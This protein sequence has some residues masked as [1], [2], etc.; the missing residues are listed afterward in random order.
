MTN[1]T[2]GNLSRYCD[3]YAAELL[4]KYFSSDDYTGGWFE[5]FAGGGD[6]AETAD[7]FTSDDIVA[8][9]FL[10][11]RIPG[12]AAIELL[13]ERA[14]EFNALLSDIPVD[15][16]LWEVPEEMVGPESPA[17]QLWSRLAELP[18]VSMIAAGKL[19]AR[20]RPRLI[21]VYDRI[22]KVALDRGDD[23]EWWLPFRAALSGK[24]GLVIA[25][26]RVRDQS[27]VGPEVSLLRVLYVSI[28]M[29]EFGRPQSVPDS[30]T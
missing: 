14:D 5:R 28:W 21:P 3:E 8:V 6:R 18:G 30:E 2:P 13:E 20:K 23:D 10:G 25:L 4:K 24:S 27:G 7:R 22:V 15:V 29:R 26:G 1:I 16:D 9:S 19:L 12:R 17:G 11:V